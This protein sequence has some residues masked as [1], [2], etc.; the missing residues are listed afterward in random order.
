MQRIRCL[1][2]GTLLLGARSWLAGSRSREIPPY[3]DIVVY[4]KVSDQVNAIQRDWDRT[5]FLRK[6][7]NQ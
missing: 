3:Q 7:V 6:M 2:G 4:A 1:P 5:R